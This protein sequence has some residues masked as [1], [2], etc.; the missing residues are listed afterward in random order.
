MSDAADDVANWMKEEIE[1]LRSNVPDEPVLN[2]FDESK[3]GEFELSRADGLDAQAWV[4]FYAG[5]LAAFSEARAVVR[6]RLV[7]DPGDCWNCDATFNQARTVNGADHCP[8]C[9]ARL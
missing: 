5:K 2:R 1:R 4:W 3:L 8:I 6:S 9:E 7:T